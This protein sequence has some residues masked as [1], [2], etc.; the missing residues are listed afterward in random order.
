M[1]VNMLRV[2]IP[3]QDLDSPDRILSCS[4]AKLQQDRKAPEPPTI[5]VLRRKVSEHSN[6][7]A[8][9]TLL[10]EVTY[11]E[12]PAGETEWPP[13]PDLAALDVVKKMRVPSGRHDPAN[14][15]RKHRN[16]SIPWRGDTGREN[17]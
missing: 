1:K 2:R 6:V 16:A 11:Q 14:R 5:R 15:F 3:V 17:D 10:V 13:M 9:N 12:L 4:Q 8:Q 7:D